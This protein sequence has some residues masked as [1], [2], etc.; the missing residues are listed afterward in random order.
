MANEDLKFCDIPEGYY[1][2]LDKMWK[3]L[4]EEDLKLLQWLMNW[5]KIDKK[6]AKKLM[7]KMFW[8]LNMWEKMKVWKMFI[9]LWLKKHG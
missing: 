9:Q 3:S 6:V 1:P 5:E 4:N 7:D 8:G 2:L